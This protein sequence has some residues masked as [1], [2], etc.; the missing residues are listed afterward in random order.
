MSALLEHLD[1]IMVA[2][3]PRG[4]FMPL[5]PARDRDAWQS[6]RQRTAETAIRRAEQ[7]AGFN[8]PVITATDV[9]LAASGDTRSFTPKYEYRRTALAALA[10]GEAMEG[11][12]RFLAD[13]VNLCFMICEESAWTLP[14]NM[15]RPDGAPMS[16][17]DIERA[18]LD[19]GAARTGALL[20]TVLHLHRDKFREASPLIAIRIER[21]ITLRVIDPFLKEPELRFMRHAGE[22]DTL[23]EGI[24]ECLTALLLIER[25][26]RY[27]WGGVKRAMQIM[28]G[29]LARMPRDG[30]I[31]GGIGAFESG[32]GCLMEA[33]E[34]IGESSGGNASFFT[35]S[36][37]RR[38][39]DFLVGS[40]I[41]LDYFNCAGDCPAHFRADANLIYRCGVLLRSEELRTL[42]AYLMRLRDGSERAPLPLMRAA[43]A[44]LGEAEMLRHDSHP[45]M[46]LDYYLRSGALMCV[47]TR[48][49][50]SDGFFA[51]LEGG[52]NLPGSH[53]DAGNMTLFWNGQPI[54]PD[55]GEI[56]YARAMPP[57][58]R[59][60]LWETQSQ[61][62][63]LPVINDRAQC[64]G[65]A[66]MAVEPVWELTPERS[67]ATL[68]ISRA[69]PE[70]A[71]VIS[72]QRT[73][74]LTRG[75]TPCVRL[76]EIAEFD[77]DSSDIEFN[78]ITTRRPNLTTSGL[79]LGE[80]LMTWDSEAG[81]LDYDV[82]ELPPPQS[83]AYDP[84]GLYDKWLLELCG[85][86]LY[87]MVLTRHGAPRRYNV[88]FTFTAR[89]E[90][91]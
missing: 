71:G 1:E 80:I 47:R 38:I 44:A 31:P 75:E 24:K 12:G 35:I 88:C 91:G 28:D 58:E 18:Q 62:H 6:V 8:W 20:A 19:L 23:P 14:E 32:A 42:G 90:Q 67:R 64:M 46:P 72:W 57:D 37:L 83:R 25:E 48:A 5:P 41:D 82:Q 9:M 70:D 2:L 43:R 52:I 50:A 69:Y 54:L 4:D 21:E 86:P 26:D 73:V 65:E 27:R 33:L 89:A 74:S 39:G 36:T 16:L 63:N 40:H 60:A 68:D 11:K 53:A 78:F 22:V 7:Y 84:E 66:F 29:Y 45:P 56:E 77:R 55:L 3:R 13:I 49:G 30:G 10:L 61:Y 81:K 79:E 85:K 51:S 59:A 17:P 76:W 15:T 34:L 87:R